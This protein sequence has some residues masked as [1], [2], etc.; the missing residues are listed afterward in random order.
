VK[1]SDG[2]F[3]KFREINTQL[4][5][6]VIIEIIVLCKQT[7]AEHKKKHYNQRLPIA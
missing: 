7:A 4:S 6:L 5:C 2:I 1:L 3:K